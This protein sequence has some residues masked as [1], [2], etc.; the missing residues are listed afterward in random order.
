MQI[1]LR[2]IPAAAGGCR[3]AARVWS[4]GSGAM[5]GTSQQI[6]SSAKRFVPVAV[7]RPLRRA[8]P[9]RYLRFVDPDWHRR[10]IGNAPYWEYMGK[11]QLDYLVERGLQP[12][13]Y[14][15]DVGCGPLRAG[16]H[17]IGY[18]E[19]G[20]YAGIDRQAEVLETARRLELPKH[21]LVAKQPRLLANHLFEF[22][23]FGLSFD[24]AIAQSVFSHLPLNN[25]MRCL[26]QISR[27]LNPGGRFYATIFENPQGKLFLD[28]IQQADHCLSHYDRDF[29]HYGLD[30]IQFACQN[31]GLSVQYEGDFGHPNNQ[32]MLL[33][34]RTGDAY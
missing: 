24:Y 29:F 33:F 3:A 2:A 28:D 26:V 20:H 11:L 34:T 27:V 16:I 4:L 23:R 30:A 9:V 25:I 19:T 22:D 7:K 15:L 31:T 17:L 12:E 13:H 10:V 1:N 6:L 18:L 21:G 14:L 5:A 32:K 8:L